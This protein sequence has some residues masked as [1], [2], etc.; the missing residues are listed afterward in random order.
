MRKQSEIIDQQG[1][2]EEPIT[3]EES[4]GDFVD[5]LFNSNKDGKEPN[6]KN[7]PD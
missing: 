2:N 7:E 3:K 1:L 4:L 6:F 5:E